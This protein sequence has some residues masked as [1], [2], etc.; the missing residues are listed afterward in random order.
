LLD[1]QDSTEDELDLWSLPIHDQFA[2]ALQAVDVGEH[3]FRRIGSICWRGKNDD[4][5]Q[6]RPVVI[7]II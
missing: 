3:T 2:L 5:G 6:C 4:G 1:V 7:S